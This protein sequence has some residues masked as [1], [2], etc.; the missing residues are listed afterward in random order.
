LSVKP[1]VGVVNVKHLLNGNL[2]ESGAEVLVGDRLLLVEKKFG[3]IYQ[4]LVDVYALLYDV[5]LVP[6]ANVMKYIFV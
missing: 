4:L 5:E 1:Y 3:Y 2:T 6:V